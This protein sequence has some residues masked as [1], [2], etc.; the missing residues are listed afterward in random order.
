VTLGIRPE[1]W[2]LVP[3]GQGGLPLEV[4]VVEEL[5][6]DGFVYGVSHVGDTAQNLILR[7]NE[8]GSVRKGDVVH[9]TTDAT[10]IHVFDTATGARLSD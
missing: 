3:A 5:G 8:R 7:V 10:R 4:A 2:R 9:V 1:A 6:A